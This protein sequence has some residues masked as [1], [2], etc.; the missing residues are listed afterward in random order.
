MAGAIQWA[1]ALFARI[2]R[3]MDRVNS[4]QQ[5][6]MQH[7]LM[8]QVVLPYRLLACCALGQIS[9]IEGPIP[10]FV[11]YMRPASTNESAIAEW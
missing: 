6:G 10:K 2:R 3:T 9:R 7:E 1:R 5:A 4:V 8:T 11:L